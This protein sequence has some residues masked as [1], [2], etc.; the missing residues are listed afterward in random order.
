MSKVIT[1]S[2][3][4]Q[5]RIIAQEDFTITHAAQIQK[6]ILS[7]VTGAAIKQVILDLTT[8]QTVDTTGVMLILGLY[9]TC[10]RQSYSLHVEIASPEIEKLLTLLQLEKYVVL[11]KVSAHGAA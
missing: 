7:N 6:E 4:N 3:E 5:I 8:I 1:Q 11:R 10:L 2:A 9:K